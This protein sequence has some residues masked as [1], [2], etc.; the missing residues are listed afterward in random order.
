LA[1]FD[2]FFHPQTCFNPFFNERPSP[3]AIAVVDQ[4]KQLLKKGKDPKAI[5]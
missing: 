2:F 3:M 4:L 5:E 1:I